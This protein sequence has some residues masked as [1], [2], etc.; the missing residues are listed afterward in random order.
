LPVEEIVDSLG[1]DELDSYRTYIGEITEEIGFDPNSKRG[2]N[3]GQVTVYLTPAQ[4]RKRTQQQIVEAIRPQIE[5]V[6]GFERLY[7]YAQKEGPPTGKAVEVGVKGDNFETLNEIATTIAEYTKTIKGVSDVTT[8]YNFGKKEMKVIVDE[9]KATQYYLTVDD[10]ATAVRNTFYGGLA[11]TVKPQKAEDEIEVLVRFQED[12]R[13]QREVFDDIIVENRLGNLVPL[14]S[15]ARID[16]KEGLHSIAH[17]DGKRVIWVTGDVDQ[18]DANS[19]SVNEELRKKFKNVS[20]EYPGYTLKFGGEYEEQKET[21]ANLLFSFIVALF[22][23]YTILVAIFKSLVQPFI[24]MTA[25]PFGILGIIIAFMMHGRDLSFF[26]LM[27]AVGLAGIVVN[28][29][30]VLVDFINRLRKSGK[31]RRASLIEAGRTRL[32]PVLMTTIT[33]IGGLVSVA[34][35]IGGGDPFLKPLGLAM[36]W[37]LLFATGLT[38]VVIPCIYAIID[39]FAEKILHIKTVK[40]NGD[41]PQNSA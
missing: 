25:I 27:G 5:S 20:K 6:E 16:V 10:I 41:P 36:V 37:G 26:A 18:I 17:Y 34:Y 22:I 29:S 3:F 28:D 19:F 12:F 14:K 32:R 31:E 39:D 38:L 7:F 15:V 11:T 21:V 1:E 9:E 8:N 30:V 35:G 40:V 24:V 4:G 13:N 23:C 2:S 33:T